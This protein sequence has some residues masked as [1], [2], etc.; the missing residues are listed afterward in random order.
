MD[1]TRADIRAN[2][3]NGGRFREGER[4]VLRCGRRGEKC[5][6]RRRGPIVLIWNVERASSREIAEGDFSGWRM[7]GMQKASR[8]E[9]VLKR[10]LQC[11]A[12]AAIV[13]SSLERG[14]T[15][16]GISLSITF[17]RGR[18]GI[19]VTSSSKT[20]SLALSTSNPSRIRS[21]V[22]WTSFRAVAITGRSVVRS[23]RRVSSKPMPREAGVVRIHGK[24]IDC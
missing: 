18:K 10:F 13:S 11:D 24:D 2:T 1:P 22:F 23:R 12:A 9:A 14:R 3:A 20:S 15:R 21:L 5:L 8:K 17:S 4:V 16:T 7:P 19:L 6:S